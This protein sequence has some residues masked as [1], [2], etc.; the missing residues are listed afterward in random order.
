MEF[1]RHVYIVCLCTRSIQKA[2]L[3]SISSE[4]GGR[5]RVTW[6]PVKGEDSINWGFGFRGAEWRLIEVIDRLGQTEM[7]S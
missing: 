2:N 6:S 4:H 3:Y 1:G 7:L 5:N